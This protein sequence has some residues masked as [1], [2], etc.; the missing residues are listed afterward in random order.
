MFYILEASPYAGRIETER[1]KS[2]SNARLNLKFYDSG[3]FEVLTLPVKVSEMTKIVDEKGKSSSLSLNAST[4]CSL[5]T[6]EAIK[7]WSVGWAG[8]AD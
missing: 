4:S 8:F 3:G 5:D 6:Y 7:V 1:D 2:T